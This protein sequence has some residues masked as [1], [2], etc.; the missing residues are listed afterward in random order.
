MPE[1][2]TPEAEKLVGLVDMGADMAALLAPS[3]PV[4]FNYPEIVGMLKRLGFRR[5]VEVARGGGG[6][7]QA[8]AGPYEI[9]PGQ[10]VYYKSL[11]DDC[12]AG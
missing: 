5:V 11:P 10:K 9:A 6:N 3:F 4:A 2:L 12:A 1:N 8:A 7:Q